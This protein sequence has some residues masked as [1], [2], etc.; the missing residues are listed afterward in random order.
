MPYGSY[1]NRKYNTDVN[2]SKTYIQ[3]RKTLNSSSNKYYAIKG[4]KD[5]K[6]EGTK[7]KI[8]DSCARKIYSAHKKYNL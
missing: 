3:I 1:Q 7:Y 2:M 4:L 5:I 8:N 6:I